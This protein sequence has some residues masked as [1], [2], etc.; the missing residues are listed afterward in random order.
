MKVVHKARNMKK[1]EAIVAILLIIGAINWG[2]VGF[3]DFD[4]IGYVFGM[5]MIDRLVYILIGIA[6]VYQIVLWAK[7]RKLSR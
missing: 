7:S 2:L 1:V 4:L 5:L 6:G 3:F